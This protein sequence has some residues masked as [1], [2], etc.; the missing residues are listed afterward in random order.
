[1]PSPPARGSRTGR[2]LLLLLAGSALLFSAGLGARDLWNPNEPLY[3]RAVVEM[4]RSGDWSLPTV[5]G[6]VFDEKPI[7]YFWMALAASAASGTVDEWTLRL[8]SALGGLAGVALVYL[9]VRPYAGPSRARLSAFAF[10]TTEIVFWS[11]RTVQMDLLL[12]VCTLGAVLAVSR[13]IDH[14]A[15][16]ACGALL[17]GLA[18]GLGVLAKGPLGLICP[19]LALAAYAVVRPAGTHGLAALAR[20]REA[21]VAALCALAGLIAVAGPWFLW[22]WLQGELDTLRELLL[23]QNVARFLAPWDHVRPWWY[24]LL[25]VWIDMA[26]WA[27][28]LPL[29]VGLRHED[30]HARRL[31]RLAAAWLIATLVFFSLS[32]SKRSPYLLPAA[33]AVAI[34]ATAPIDLWLRGLL[35]PWRRRLLHALIGLAGAALAALGLLLAYRGI[36]EYPTLVA[37]GRMVAALLATGGLAVL[38]LSSPPVRRPRAG[39]R[40][41]AAVLVALYLLAAIWMLPAADS[42]KSARPFCEELLRLVPPERSLRSYRPWSWRASYVYYTDRTIAPIDSPPELE[43]YWAEPSEVFLLVERDRLDEVQRVLGPV[44]PRLARQVGGNAVYLFSNRTSSPPG[45]P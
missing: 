22:L 36:D 29:A 23:R 33:P 14:G 6:R 24:F 35:D 38:L 13:I 2:D 11:A 43:R 27:L 32:A 7:L 20:H 31:D 26:P 15:A 28:L 41:F 17:A 19:G 5:N 16:V 4:S 12:A 8:P 18:A 3:G 34:L 1:V 44:E 45:S 10:A 9:L 21:W 39:A 42:F 40:V 30:R 25:Y 37:P